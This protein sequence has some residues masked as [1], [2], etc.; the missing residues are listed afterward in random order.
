MK[1]EITDLMFYGKWDDETDEYPEDSTWFEKSSCQYFQTDTLMDEFGYE[2]YEDIENCGCFIPVFRRSEQEI[3]R[4]FIGLYG[5]KSI[6]DRIQKIIDDE[7]EEFGVAFR[8]YAEVHLDFSEAYLKYENEVLE[9]DAKKWAEENGVDFYEDYD[10]D[11]KVN[12]DVLCRLFYYE[13]NS[14]PGFTHYWFS[15]KDFSEIDSSKKNKMIANGELIQ[16]EIDRDYIIIPAV[17]ES[18]AKKAGKS[19]DDLVKEVA[20]NWCKENEIKWYIPSNKPE[21]RKI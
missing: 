13:D 10:P 8:I 4:K 15:K 21:H 3:M 14:T 17:T 9:T 7:D 18:E 11:R 6:S 12:F 1:T 20:L 2:S 16:K 19:W 5:D